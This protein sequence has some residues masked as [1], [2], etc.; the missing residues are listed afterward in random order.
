VQDDIEDAGEELWRDVVAIAKAVA[1][2]F[3]LNDT[4]GAERATIQAL[5]D[6]KLHPAFTSDPVRVDLSPD[7]HAAE[8]TQLTTDIAYW[9][10]LFNQPIVA[11]YLAKN[12]GDIHGAF[13]LYERIVESQ[14]R[15]ID[16]HADAGGRVGKLRKDASAA[17][18]EYLRRLLDSGTTPKIEAD[19]V[20]PSLPPREDHADDTDEE[21][22]Q[23]E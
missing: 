2:Q 12:P 19:G 1:T 20:V 16:T 21:E 4:S 5:A 9:N 17:N 11:A 7:P 22:S 14:Q 15:A 6:A 23:E 18:L 3:P 8:L 10:S 13:A